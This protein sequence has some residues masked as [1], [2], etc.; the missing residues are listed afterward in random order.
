MNQVSEN[1]QVF[2]DFQSFGVFSIFLYPQVSALCTGTSI[3]R[4]DGER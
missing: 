4:H 3:S 2:G 1:F